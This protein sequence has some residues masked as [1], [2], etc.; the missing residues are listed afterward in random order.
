MK[1]LSYFQ[2]S[3]SLYEEYYVTWGAGRGNPFQSSV[4]KP[5]GQRWVCKD[6]ALL[7][8]QLK[9]GLNRA[10]DNISVCGGA[11]GGGSVLVLERWRCGHV[12]VGV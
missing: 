6:G 12:V 4:L 8:V 11:V 10:A 9:T 2:R 5:T 3:L 7:C 1:S